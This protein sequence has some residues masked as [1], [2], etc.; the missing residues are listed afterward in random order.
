MSGSCAAPSK[1]HL[2]SCVVGNPSLS[3]IREGL[4][5]IRQ[6]STRLDSPA[7]QFSCMKR[8]KAVRFFVSYQKL[9]A[10]LA[11]FASDLLHRTRV[12]HRLVLLE[13]VW[14]HTRCHYGNHSLQPQF[15]GTLTKAEFE[16]APQWSA[17]TPLQ[18]C[19]RG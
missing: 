10:P 16:G 13:C 3:G 6:Q 19:R 9:F 2:N 11:V 8:C 4:P 1:S 5:V 15:G 12:Q 18:R 14:S 17:C 7:T